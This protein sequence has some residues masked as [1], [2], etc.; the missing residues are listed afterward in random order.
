MKNLTYVLKLTIIIVI[1]VNVRVIPRNVGW[2][3]I[4]GLIKFGGGHES[5]TSCGGCGFT[6]MDG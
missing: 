1:K 2:L 3:R 6:M 5:F 4:S